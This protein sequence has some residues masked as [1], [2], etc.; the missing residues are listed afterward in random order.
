MAA[1]SCGLL[2]GRQSTV[3]DVEYLLLDD[4]LQSHVSNDE[5]G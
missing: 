2:L 5:L 1:H 4:S 3:P